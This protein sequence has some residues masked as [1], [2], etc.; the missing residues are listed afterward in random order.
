[1]PS[2]D[3]RASEDVTSQLAKEIHLKHKAPI[4][5]I[6]VIDGNGIPLP[7]SYEVIKGVSKVPT[8]TGHRVLICSEEQFKLFNL[9]NLKPLNKF[10]LTAH[11][12]ARARR[13]AIAQFHQQIQ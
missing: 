12:G 2:D 9:P 5:A 10:K 3:K 13:I 7:D 8:A 1:M 4:I 6:Y 11:E